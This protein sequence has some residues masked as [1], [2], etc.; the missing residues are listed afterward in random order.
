MDHLDIHLRAMFPQQL[1]NKQ[2]EDRLKPFKTHL[3]NVRQGRNELNL[4]EN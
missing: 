3:V 2:D 4:G 1:K